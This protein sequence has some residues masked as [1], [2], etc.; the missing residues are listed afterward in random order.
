MELP[1][2]QLRLNSASVGSN[3]APSASSRGAA[4]RVRR[5]RDI[6]KIMTP[7]LD[8]PQHTVE[9]V[10]K[11]AK[12]ELQERG[13]NQGGLSGADGKVCLLGAVNCAMHGTPDSFREEDCVGSELFILD[14]S[15]KN[16]LNKQAE[17]HGFLSAA[18]F[19]D[20]QGRTMEEIVQ[21]IDDA[22]LETKTRK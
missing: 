13:W 8:E 3:P 14:G 12:L 11:R 10:L 18:L 22:I 16:A 2:K 19:N 5:R 20:H 9:T 15:T 4:G 21:L 6:L 17:R 1:A 7:Q